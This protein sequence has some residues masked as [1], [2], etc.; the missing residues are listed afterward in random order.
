MFYPAVHQAQYFQNIPMAPGLANVGG[1]A[2]QRA[3]LQANG[4]PPNLQL[5]PEVAT[6]NTLYRV[7]EST[8]GA[9]TDR[10]INDIMANFQ[11]GHWDRSRIGSLYWIQH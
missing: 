2:A 4:Y 3:A 9:Y 10:T 6:A 11:P 7:R 5:A 8:D 1:P